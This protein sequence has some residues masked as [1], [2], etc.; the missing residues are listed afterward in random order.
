M[1]NGRPIRDRKVVYTGSLS[2]K[3]IFETTRAGGYVREQDNV[4]KQEYVCQRQLLQA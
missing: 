2:T 4:Y 3:S 1:N